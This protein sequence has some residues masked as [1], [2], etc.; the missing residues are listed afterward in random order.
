MITVN[1]LKELRVYVNI[2][3]KLEETQGL[4]I[5]TIDP[6]TGVLE[7]SGLRLAAF[8]VTFHGRKEPNWYVVRYRLDTNMYDFISFSSKKIAISFLGVCPVKFS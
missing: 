1:E 6:I 8:R 7:N 4:K 2:G 3:L 5:E